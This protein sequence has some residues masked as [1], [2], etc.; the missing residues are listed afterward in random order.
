MPRVRTRPTRQ[1]TA[2]RLVSGARKAITERSFHGATVDHICEAA[3]LTRGAFYS[4]FKTKEELFLELYGRVSLDV[5]YLLGNALEEALK[6]DG[7]P[8]DTMFQ[9]FAAAYPLGRE[10]YILNAEMTLVA[11]R[12]EIAAA[13]FAK[14]RQTLRHMVVAKIQQVLDMSSRRLTIDP[15]LLARALIGLTDAGLGQSLIEPDKLGRSTF[16]EAICPVILKSCS[17]PLPAGGS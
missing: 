2:D 14:R 8:I 15:D 10:W 7:D 16:I 12:S 1:D 4:G 13:T 3:V 17:E 9:K 5:A 11:L 6:G